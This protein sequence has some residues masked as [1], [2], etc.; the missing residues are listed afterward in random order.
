MSEGLGSPPAHQQEVPVDYQP[1]DQRPRT[2][3]T[4]HSKVDNR[5]FDLV[6]INDLVEVENLAYLRRFDTALSL[7]RQLS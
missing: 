3:R 5:S 7:T 6:A 2:H 4:R 1:R